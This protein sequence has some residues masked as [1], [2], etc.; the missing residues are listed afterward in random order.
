[1]PSTTLTKDDLGTCTLSHTLLAVLIWKCSIPHRTFSIVSLSHC[2]HLCLLSQLVLLLWLCGWTGLGSPCKE[3]TG[4][5]STSVCMLHWDPSSCDSR[6]TPTRKN[7]GLGGGPSTNGVLHHMCS[8]FL[9]QQIGIWV[10]IFVWS[11]EN[12]VKEKCLLDFELV[13]CIVLPRFSFN[14]ALILTAFFSNLLCSWK[15]SKVKWSRE[16]YSFLTM[17]FCSSCGSM[18]MEYIHAFPL[19]WFWHSERSA[20]YGLHL[21]CIYAR[22]LRF[23]P[24]PKIKLMSI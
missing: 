7:R 6:K 13:M 8:H 3:L 23:L 10:K 18:H 9:F 12:K 17:S 20:Q 21:L 4:K 15:F 2:S 24:S 1:M 11:A 19:P 16:R 14:V 22:E 5:G